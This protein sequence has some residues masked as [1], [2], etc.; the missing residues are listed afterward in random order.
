MTQHALPR[1]GRDAIVAMAAA[2]IGRGSKSFALASRLFDRITRERAWLFYAWCRRADDLADGQDHGGTGKAAHDPHGKAH[3]P[4]VSREIVDNVNHIA[5]MTRLALA[6]ERTGDPAFDALGIVAAEC[7]IPHGMIADII[8]GF[9]L[10]AAG[11]RP[12][13]EDALLRYCYHVAGAVGCVMAVVMGVDPA[14]RAT[15]DRAC[16]QGIAFQLA[17]IA[18]DVAEDAG[19]GRC[20]LPAT[21]LAEAGI[22][23]S[24]VLHPRHREAV[25]AMIARLAGMAEAY[26]ASGQ[27]GAAR[28]P[29]RARWAVLAASGIYG[30]IAR[31][32]RRRGAGALDARVVTPMA[33]KLG[34]IARALARAIS[35]PPEP[36]REGL[37]T[38]P[39]DAA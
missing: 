28:L 30:D 26:E 37:W 14:D 5:A 2:S 35:P 32:A 10:D 6:G 9:E 24:D 38:R 20:Y 18:R 31:E 17:N 7:G 13:D 12:A 19:N 34:W 1:A 25:A 15:L 21:W 4:E 29:F 33:A 16:D 22:G 36:P 27:G 3:A 23:E 8:E 39:H 11:W